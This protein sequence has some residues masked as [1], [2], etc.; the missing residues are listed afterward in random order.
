MND[1]LSKI[2][3][4]RKNINI[5]GKKIRSRFTA[6]I[7]D[8]RRELDVLRQKMDDESVIKF[9]E[10]SNKIS[11]PIA[12][13]EAYWKQQP[14]IFWLKDGDI[15]SKFFHT[16]TTTKKKLNNITSMTFE[17]DSDLNVDKIGP[18]IFN[19]DNNALFVPFTMNEFKIA[20]YQM[21]SN[22]SPGP[23]G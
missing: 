22:K 14:K 8:C 12:Q 21:D 16:S 5:Q 18:C 13:E 3:A 20:L 6:R 1:F 2:K 17:E 19:D 7:D 15:N 10:V 11:N 23:N 9:Q 4:C